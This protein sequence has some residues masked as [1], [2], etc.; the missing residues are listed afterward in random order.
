MAT[1]KKQTKR[2]SVDKDKTT[3]FVIVA[4]AALLVTGSLVV[5]KNLLSQGNYLSKVAGKKEVALKQLE[6]NKQAASTLEQSYKD[7]ANQ[8]PNLIGGTVAGKGERDGD[9]AKLILDALPSKYDFPA[10]TASIE[11]MLTGYSIEEI[12]G[13]DDALSQQSAVPAGS[14][15]MPFSMDI[16]TNYEGLRT[17]L[18]KLD[19]S[20]RPFQITKIDLSGTNAA[21]Q[22]KIEAKTYYQPEKGLQITNESVI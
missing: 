10:L 20:I 13:V 3:I 21:L 18:E 5:S 17:L 12:E 22:S 6:N 9:N 4:I 19:R 1:A 16:I 7:F 14:V 11:K 15:E 2:A 8:D